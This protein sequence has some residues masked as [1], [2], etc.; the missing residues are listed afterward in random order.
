MRSRPA[1]RCATAPAARPERVI[2][3]PDFDVTFA[4]GGPYTMV[5]R[6]TTVGSDLKVEVGSG[7]V[8]AIVG[9]NGAVKTLTATDSYWATHRKFEALH[10]LTHSAESCPERTKA[11]DVRSWTVADG[12]HTSLIAPPGR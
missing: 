2:L 6:M 11:H 3:F 7:N 1:Y 9:P 5:Q 10:A 8:L 4:A 12:W